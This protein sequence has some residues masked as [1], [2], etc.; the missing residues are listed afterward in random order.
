MP[1][2]NIKTAV[3]LVGGRSTRMGR[4]KFAMEINGRP[5]WKFMV[6][7][8]STFFD[9]V[10]ISCRQDQAA[11]FEGHSLIFD[12]V[13]DIG[14]MGAIH[15]AFQKLTQ[16]NSIFFVA[17]D[18][19]LFKCSLSVKLYDQLSDDYDVISAWNTRRGSAEPLVA[20]WNRSAIP[21]INTFMAEQ[22][23]ALFKCMAQLRVKTI[24]IKESEQLRNVNMTPVTHCY[25]D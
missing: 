14:P 13:N 3:L 24:E 9:Q 17:C 10:F 12:E 16:T 2:S 15:S 21:R 8:L 7:E 25:L 18:M 4:D 1:P 5:Q 23:Y 19:P 11:H 22:N 20:F 6:D